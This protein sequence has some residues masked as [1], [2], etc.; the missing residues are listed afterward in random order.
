MLRRSYKVVITSVYCATVCGLDPES[1][2]A[3]VHEHNEGR[4]WVRPHVW[5]RNYKSRVL[6]VPHN[7]SS[8]QLPVLWCMARGG[9]WILMRGFWRLMNIHL[10]C[11]TNA[12]GGG[13]SSSGTDNWHHHLTGLRSHKERYLLSEQDNHNSSMNEDFRHRQQN[14]NRENPESVNWRLMQKVLQQ[15]PCRVN[16]YENQFHRNKVKLPI[17]SKH[18]DVSSH[19]WLTVTILSV[20][21]ACDNNTILTSEMINF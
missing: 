14:H 11:V 6:T 10:L 3:R 19:N 15:R 2:K 8:A 5:T 4:Y 9:S 21:R 20:P 17:T 12:A 7:I 13:S 16:G 1:S 18:H